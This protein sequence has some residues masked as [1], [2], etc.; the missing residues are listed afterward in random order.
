MKVGTLVQSRRMPA[1]GA[2][3]VLEIAAGKTR[4]HFTA[5]GQRHLL[6]H[7]ADL[8]ELQDSE[9]PADSAIR[10]DLGRRRLASH[11][12]VSTRIIDLVDRFNSVFPNKFDGVFDRE[13]RDYKLAAKARL[14]DRLD[15]PE[16]RRLLAA[17]QATEVM[18]RAS[19]VI[20]A[21]NLVY[22]IEMLKFRDVP[23]GAAPTVAEALCDLLEAEDDRLPAAL[24]AL[25]QALDPWDAA[26]WPIVTYFPFLQRPDR[27]PFVKPFAVQQAA[28]ALGYDIGY[29]VLPSA[30]AYRRVM[31]LYDLVGKEMAKHGLHARDLIDVQTFLWYG[32][33][34][35]TDHVARGNAERI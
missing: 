27:M 23:T 18:Q 1:W 20:G 28:Q 33:G 21:T 29:T 10:T 25:G 3:I 14:H 35:G 24:E 7:Q 26:K 16:L 13:E 32:C 8:E 34:L 22:R 4:V 5:G 30:A 15:P 31:G 12:A 2:G 19:Q 9:V 11:Q 6:L 17:G